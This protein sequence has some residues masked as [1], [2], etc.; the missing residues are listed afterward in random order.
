MS[1]DTSGQA[2]ATA[3]LATLK[4]K[5]KGNSASAVQPH[6]FDEL[7]KNDLAPIL[8]QKVKVYSFD[9]PVQIVF[10]VDA[11]FSCTQKE[12]DYLQSE[13]IAPFLHELAQG[14]AEAAI[15][16]LASFL[17]Q[18]DESISSGAL[19][20]DLA[21]LIVDGEVE[22]LNTHACDRISQDIE[23]S[24]KIF[25]RNKKA[26]TV[27]K[28]RAVTSVVTDTISIIG[29]AAHAGLSWGGSSPIAIVMIARSC[30]S[31]VQT[32]GMA[33]AKADQVAWLIDKDFAVL[34][35][36]ISEIASSD[37]EKLKKL[38]NDAAEVG[39]AL[40]GELAGVKLP[41]IKNCRE[42]IKEYRVKITELE[43]KVQQLS[44][45][46]TEMID[47]NGKLIAYIEALPVASA[48][49]GK[50]KALLLS[51]FEDG[52]GKELT[53]LLDRVA[54]LNMQVKAGYINA[55][56]YEERLKLLSESTH[57]AVQW[58][59]TVFSLG[60]NSALNVG[61]P[62][63]AVERGLEAVT[64]LMEEGIKLLVDKTG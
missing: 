21:Q 29:H 49:A 59:S 18:L 17:L 61:M 24:A 54:D 32:V 39:L 2:T 60:I 16:H 8:R 36:C 4:K 41:S 1:Q 47:L 56:G 44:P 53:K 38:R 12:F 5:P 37:R 51:V 28:I 3:A 40:L 52:A 10:V 34:D 62:E 26:V 14:Y 9:L 23:K 50:H 43:L 55:A 42:R 45:Q 20:T 63:E 64:S 31:I 46:I 13:G 48:A 15:A 19:R 58:A 22:K 27:S 7:Y 35:V 30:V 6:H 33:V 11:Q 57:S 25:T